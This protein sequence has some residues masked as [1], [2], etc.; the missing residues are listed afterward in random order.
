MPKESG[1]K[2]QKMTALNARVTEQS[3]DMLKIAKVLQKRSLQELVQEAID[4]WLK[5]HGYT[6]DRMP[7]AEKP[8]K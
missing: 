7:N 1:T 2:D 4:N 5:A 3:M 6:P 8:R